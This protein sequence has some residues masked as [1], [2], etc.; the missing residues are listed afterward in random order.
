[1]VGGRSILLRMNGFEHVT[2]VTDLRCRHMAED[3]PV[4]MH[5]AA[6]PASLGE[7]IR[8]ALDEPAAGV[9]DDELHA[10]Q[11]AIDQVP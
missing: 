1:M 2:Y 4:K 5:H 3:I 11:A 8:D 7:I 9:G 10:L 6:L